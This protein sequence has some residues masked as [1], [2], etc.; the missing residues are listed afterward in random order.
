MLTLLELAAKASYPRG[1]YGFQKD[2]GIPMINGS[3]VY[4]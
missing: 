1:S 2:E 4:A 3:S